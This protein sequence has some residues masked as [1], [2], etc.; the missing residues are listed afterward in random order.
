MVYR[1]AFFFFFDLPV[2]IKFYI[3]CCSV[4]VDSD[5]WLKK[6]T[7]ASVFES[8]GRKEIGSLSGWS[9]VECSEMLG[10]QSREQKPSCWFMRFWGVPTP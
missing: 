7:I 4:L 1:R 9:L 10:L 3:P 2:Q 6:N 8:L 5:L